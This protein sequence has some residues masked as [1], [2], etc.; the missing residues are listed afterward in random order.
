[1]NKNG[2]SMEIAVKHIVSWRFI[3][4][5]ED[6][7]VRP[8]MKSSCKDDP[9]ILSFWNT[10]NRVPSFCFVPTSHSQS[11]DGNALWSLLGIE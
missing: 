10:Q 1:M 5:D 2:T 6:H 8:L 3:L 4:D 7:P 9:R 11:P